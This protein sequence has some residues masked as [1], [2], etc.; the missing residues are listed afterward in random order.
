MSKFKRFIA[1]LFNIQPEDLPQ[2]PGI[3]KQTEQA[4]PYTREEINQLIRQQVMQVMKENLP[5]ET[6]RQQVSD[7]I[8]ERREGGQEQA[9]PA[10]TAP[11]AVKEIQEPSE[12]VVAQSEQN[13]AEQ[14]DEEFPVLE[15]EDSPVEE[16]E[17]PA[18]V[19]EE[20]IQI[21]HEVL[22]IVEDIFPI[23]E[24][25]PVPLPIIETQPP[26]LASIEG[27]QI[28]LGID[29]GTTT[30][31]VSI[32]FGDDLPIALPIGQDGTTAYI[33]SVVFFA[34]GKD[35]LEH[36]ATVG[37]EAERYNDPSRTIRS[38][39]RCFGC[40]GE[41]CKSERR[42]SYCQG[43]GAIQLEGEGPIKPSFVAKLIVKEA[44]R[45]SIH[46][47]RDRWQI[48]LSQENV[49]ILPVNFGCGAKFD[50]I[51]R[52][53]ICEI[54]AELGFTDFSIQNVVEEPILAGFAF[55]RFA[56]NPIGRSLIYD[57]GGGTFDAAI[58]EVDE[59]GQDQRVTILATSADNWLGGD[60]I[61]T[62]IYQYFLEQIASSLPDQTPRMIE[63][64]LSANNAGRI[65]Q[66]AKEAKEF[67]SVNDTY[68]VTLPLPP[69]GLL[70]LHLDRPTFE[71]LLTES[72][73][74]KRSLDVVNHACRLVRVYDEA[75]RVDSVDSQSILGLTLAKASTMID[76]V[77]LVGG[78]TKV[79][80]VRKGLVEIFGEDKIIQ[81]T[82]IEPV[83]AVAIGGAYPHNPEHFSI[84]VPP[85]GYYLT[86]Q[87]HGKMVKDYIVRPYDFYDFNRYW[88][89][90][91]VGSFTIPVKVL[92]NR[93]DAELYMERSGEEEATLLKRWT[94]L[95]MG[96]WELTFNLDG[97]IGFQRRGEGRN[98]L[99]VDIPKHPRQ[100]AIVDARNA[101][102]EAKRRE[103][104]ENWSFDDDL[105]SM[106]VDP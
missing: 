88:A 61:D 84:V 18:P 86:Y 10:V 74:V 51:Q 46:Y 3:Q 4:V 63:S 49:C 31:A 68:D 26:V 80:F 72:E 2:Q 69:L 25:E 39:K 44:L 91:S 87:R 52:N 64:S 70:D 5:Q 14:L 104:D 29:F 90:S 92:E 34:P 89:T 97:N 50:L 32:K 33:P 22:P 99:A 55:S 13:V 98:D 1:R 101:R 23:I 47:V 56:K 95:G 45:R 41:A 106:R 81:E 36:R 59:E 82:V 15:E 75:C 16:S 40:K 43:N 58:I 28:R 37:E 21:P 105:R 12:P 30:T 65:K 27:K 7:Q 19:L 67:L 17:L 96:E 102:Y 48:D 66:R 100:Q 78:V 54:A 94:T 6:I 60:D 62:V 83:S 8:P 79:P 71:S 42:Q 76:H 35:P 85:F 20:P 9:E 11:Q 93:P 24:K 77:V 103:E 57:F 38:V 73:L 53:V